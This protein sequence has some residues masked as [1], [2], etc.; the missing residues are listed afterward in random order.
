M[1]GNYKVN[2]PM[3]QSFLNYCL[4]LLVYTTILAFRKGDD[5]LWMIL[6]KRSW[7]YALLGLADV[8]A[9]YMVVKAYQYTTLTSVQLLD[10]FTIPIVMGLSWFTLH[11]KYKV[12]HFVSVLICLL[13]VGAMVGAD[14]LAGREQGAGS[15][16]V[17]G[18]GLVLI[19]A[20]LYAI[21]NVSEEFIVKN[22]SREEFLGMLGVFG[23][24]YSAIQMAILE[25]NE[26]ADVQ[27]DG[28]VVLLYIVFA[29]CMFGLYNLMPVVIK[30]SSA[31]S[32]NLGILTADLYSLFIGIFLFDYTFSGLYI[33][34]FIVIISVFLLYSIVSIGITEPPPVP[35]VICTGFDNPVLELERNKEDGDDSVH[36][37]SGESAEIAAVWKSNIH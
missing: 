4:L 24:L 33:L 36:F 35:Q 21:S 19:G 9:N 25:H 23:T 3:L 6:K 13:G 31:T 15:N 32:V 14:A 2:T 22:L 7:K 5:N 37:V 10:C 34:S 30:I 1:A 18:D 12:M 16:K 17:L 20:L 27:W 8:E 11:S 29:V 26:I 28:I